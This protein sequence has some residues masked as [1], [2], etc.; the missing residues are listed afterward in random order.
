MRTPSLREG[1]VRRLRPRR[2]DLLEGS[3]LGDLGGG[4]GYSGDGVGCN[5][6]SRLTSGGV[7]LGA[8][9]SESYSS[10]ASFT[11]GGVGR[12]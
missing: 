9:S 5:F 11:V 7:R 12:T 6:T 8:A 4:V 1:C 10:V 2:F 3:G